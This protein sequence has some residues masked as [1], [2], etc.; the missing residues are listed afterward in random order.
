M[1]NPIKIIIL[2]RYLF[3]SHQ[4]KNKNIITYKA[5]ISFPLNYK[6]FPKQQMLDSSKLKE[7]ADDNFELKRKWKKV[8]QT[9][10]KHRGK[11]RN[12][13]L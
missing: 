7:F 13:L 11:R 6:P 2:E 5:E 10:R 9:G 4:L 3:P 1:S 8:I 12:C